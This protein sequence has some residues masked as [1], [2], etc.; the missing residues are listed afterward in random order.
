MLYLVLLSLA[1]DNL[2]IDS[3]WIFFDI[4]FFGL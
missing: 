4:R 3:Y 1:L 2:V